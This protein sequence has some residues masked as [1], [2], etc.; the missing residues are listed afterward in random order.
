[1]GT[2][3]MV[4]SVHRQ[5]MKSMKL[6]IHHMHLPL[7]P[8]PILL[9]RSLLIH[10]GNKGVGIVRPYTWIWTDPWLSLKQ[11]EK[12][13][14]CWWMVHENLNRDACG[15]EECL[16]VTLKTNICSK[17]GELQ[18]RV[19]GWT[20]NFLQVLNLSSYSRGNEALRKSPFPLLESWN[21]KTGK[22]VNTM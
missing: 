16:M 18:W 13:S 2:V 17:W 4:F 14:S 10:S 3:E 6:L 22:N 1:M 15:L 5:L 19:S 12:D 11:N 8:L 20:S 21:V 7:T 9:P